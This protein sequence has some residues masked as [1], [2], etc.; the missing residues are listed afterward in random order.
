MKILGYEAVLQITDNEDPPNVIG[1]VPIQFDPDSYELVV[2]MPATQSVVDAYIDTNAPQVGL[3]LRGVE[4]KNGSQIRAT[5]NVTLAL[6]SQTGDVTW[7]LPT[8]AA[9]IPA[10][11]VERLYY[12]SSQLD[13]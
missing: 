8:G 5:Q 12:G 1:V 10:S 6:D 13:Q 2:D 7:N 9:V 11:A 4:L 3:A